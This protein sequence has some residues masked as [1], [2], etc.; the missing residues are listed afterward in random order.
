[1]GAR[2]CWVFCRLRAG[3][4]WCHAWPPRI[5]SAST[6]REERSVLVMHSV[7]LVHVL[8][9]CCR[10][11]CCLLERTQSLTHSFAVLLLPSI[12]PRCSSLQLRFDSNVRGMNG[13]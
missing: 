8:L 6:R 7:F 5:L 2:E 4:R 3:C 12:L 13:M 9:S 11:V 10:A 1:M